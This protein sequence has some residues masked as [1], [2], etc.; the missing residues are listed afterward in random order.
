MA[1]ASQNARGQRIPSSSVAVY[2]AK[3]RAKARVVLGVAA[4]VV[5]L[6]LIHI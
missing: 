4:L 3:R 2:R 1:L 6:S 5:L